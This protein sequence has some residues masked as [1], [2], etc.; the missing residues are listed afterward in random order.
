[1]DYIQIKQK[2]FSKVMRG[3]D[4]EEVEDFIDQIAEDQEQL[5]KE[6]SDLRE[7]IRSLE[8]Q[9]AAKEI[10]DK[11]RETG[12]I[13]AEIREIII[14]KVDSILDGI[15]AAVNDILGK[16]TA[17]EIELR[18]ELS[19]LKAQEKNLLDGY[20]ELRELVNRHIQL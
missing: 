14:R 11:T 5:L 1:M 13:D 19:R 18:Q 3:F 8:A 7:R 10:E 4:P 6:N 12:T 15:K 20:R 9:L 17:D 16:A 2:V